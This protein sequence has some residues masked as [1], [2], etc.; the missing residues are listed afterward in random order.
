M[1]RTIIHR[2][3][4][5]DDPI[6]GKIKQAFTAIQTKNFM[7]KNGIET[8]LTSY[9][10][11]KNLDDEIEKLTG[12][13]LKFNPKKWIK[14]LKKLKKNSLTWPADELASKTDKTNIF[15]KNKK[16]Y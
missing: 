3:Q 6:S 11:N 12:Q 9:G 5:K 15:H 2:K 14:T 4:I 1:T 16:I 10:Q 8:S 13:V 7:K